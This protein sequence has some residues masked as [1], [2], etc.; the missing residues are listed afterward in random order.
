MP[1][2]R[3][4]GIGAAGVNDPVPGSYSS[5]VARRPVAFAP[6]ATSTFPVPR[7]VAVCSDRGAA[8]DPV[9]CTVARASAEKKPA[10]V[11]SAAKTPPTRTD[12]AE[13]ERCAMVTSAAFVGKTLAP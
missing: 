6:P 3:A 9:G 5:A 4:A 13:R 11:A 12:R 10:M 8:I 2:L 7:N 1:A